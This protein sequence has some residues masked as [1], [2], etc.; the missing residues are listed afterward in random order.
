MDVIN[1]KIM[2]SG[3]LETLEIIRESVAAGLD[4]M[5]GGMVETRI[6]MG[7]SYA[8][9]LSYPAI[10]YLDLDTPLLMSEDPLEGGYS[11]SGPRLIPSGDPGLG[12]QLRK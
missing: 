7:C 11:Y 4:L 2:K 1:L 3:V 9:A 10:K 6:G 8:L 5:I 12:M